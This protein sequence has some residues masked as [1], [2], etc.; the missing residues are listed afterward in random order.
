M[1]KGNSMTFS[2]EVKGLDEAMRKLKVYDTNSRKR[3]EKAVSKAG[4][5][6]RDGAKSRAPVKSG[7]L[8]DSITARFNGRGMLS[9]VKTNGRKA[10][11]AHLIEFGVEATTVKPHK[12]KAMKME[13]AAG[14]VFVRR[15][16]VTIPKRH[17]EPF[18]EPAF[19]AEEPKVE[20]EIK[21]ILRT[22]P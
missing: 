12:K 5:N 19:R 14:N 9:V 6:G 18:M 3:I 10:P 21:Q 8:R 1:P 16:A 15:G 13:N 11:H 20:N 22:M 2:M 17:A 7:T 4:R